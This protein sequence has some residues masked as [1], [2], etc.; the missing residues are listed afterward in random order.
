M[1]KTLLSTF[2]LSSLLMACTSDNTA[3]KNEITIDKT[4]KIEAVANANKIE[5]AKALLLA[6]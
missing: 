6:K 2:L 4:S 1:K 3:V 5:Q